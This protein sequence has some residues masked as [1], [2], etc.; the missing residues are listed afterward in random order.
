MA[1][2]DIEIENKKVILTTD[3]DKMELYTYKLEK[4][5]RILSNTNEEKRIR[6]YE[7]GASKNT[8]FNENI[9]IAIYVIP[10]QIIGGE[11]EIET[12][13]VE[14]MDNI[15]N[16]TIV[17]HERG[18]KKIMK[19][20]IGEDAVKEFDNNIQ[21]LIFR[22]NIEEKDKYISITNEM[23]GARE[24]LPK[25]D[26]KESFIKS[27]NS[28][29]R[30]KFWISEEENT[31]TALVNSNEK[32]NSLCIHCSEISQRDKVAFPNRASGLMVCSD[33]YGDFLS[34]YTSC[35]KSEIIARKI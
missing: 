6:R 9:D 26:F 5:L 2:E 14:I 8:F 21:E 19:K 35:R 1:L 25:E 3:E 20:T 32:R 15:D 13:E 18:L 34:N 10:N 7:V 27:I 4:I 16:N 22:L 33:C 11:G 29:E 12:I 23:C 28:D 30:N 24:K 17:I 31:S